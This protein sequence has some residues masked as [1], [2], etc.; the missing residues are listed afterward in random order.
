LAA[1]DVGQ[2]E[3]WAT[4]DGDRSWIKLGVD[5]DNQSPFR[6][7]LPG[8]GLYGFRIVVVGVDG[9]GPIAPSADSEPELTLG[10]D[11]EPPRARILGAAVVQGELADHLVIRWTAFDERLADGSIELSYS[12]KPDGPWT[13]FADDLTNIGEYR[14]RLT[15]AL[16][17]QIYVRMQVKDAAGNTATSTMP[18]P[19]AIG[20]PQPKGRLRGVRPASSD[21]ARF[22]TADRQPAA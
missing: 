2:I 15:P 1:T 16:P 5:A 19:V 4:R 11:V 8:P 6:T 13:T 20:Q 3:L 17:K 22:H 12:D 21:D 18:A 9:S 7:T 10:V 14:W